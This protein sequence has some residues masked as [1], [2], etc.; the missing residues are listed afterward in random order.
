MK[1]LFLGI[2]LSSIVLFSSNLFADTQ[3]TFEWDPSPVNDYVLGYKLYDNM[4]EIDNVTGTTTQ[5]I[6]SDGDHSFTVTCYNE[7][8]ESPHSNSIEKTYY[9]AAPGQPTGFLATDE[10]TIP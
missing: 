3:V 4:I 1:K 7:N 9:T 8:G 2:I 10:V 5:V 6:V